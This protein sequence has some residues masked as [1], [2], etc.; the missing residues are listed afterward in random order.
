MGF[1]DFIGNVGASIFG[2][3]KNEAEEIKKLIETDLGDKITD[4]NVEF[5]DGQALLSGK[6][7]SHATKEKAVLLAG[8]IKGVEKVNDDNLTAPEPVEETEF[9]TIQRGDSLSKIAKR[10]YGNA[11]KYPVIF[12]AN[13]E[14]IKDP[15]LIY[16][17]Q[18][19]RIPKLK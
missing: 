14:V 17:G 18:V 13:R 1:F 9:Y 10:Y 7:D 2:G 19:L 16:P 11:M 3:G 5:N 4:L 8:N 15:D 12:E 6:C